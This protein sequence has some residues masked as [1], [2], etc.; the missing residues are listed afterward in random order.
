MDYR[1]IYTDP[2]DKRRVR[3][4]IDDRRRIPKEPIDNSTHKSELPLSIENQIFIL[5]LTLRSPIGVLFVFG[6]SGREE[7]AMEGLGGRW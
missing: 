3:N 1:E 6:G 4:D 5:K 7:I 2:L